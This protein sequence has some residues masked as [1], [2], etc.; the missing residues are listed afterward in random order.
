MQFHIRF[1]RLEKLLK[2]KEGIPAVALRFLNGTI[3]WADRIFPNE[4]EFYKAVERAFRNEPPAPGPRVVIITFRR[5]MKD[6]S[7]DT[8]RCK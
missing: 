3:D 2:K 8:L 5:N 4:E 1:L 6:F 7:L